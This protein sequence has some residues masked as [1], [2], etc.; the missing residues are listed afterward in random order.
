[1]DH[2]AA[3]SAAAR[4]A[5][6][7]RAVARHLALPGPKALRRS[8]ARAGGG[9]RLRNRISVSCSSSSRR[10]QRRPRIEKIARA[11]LRMQLPAATR[12]Q[13]VP[14]GG[15][16][17]D[18]AAH[19][20]RGTAAPAPALTTLPRFRAPLVFGGLA[21]LFAVLALRVAVSAMDRQRVSSRSREARATAARSRSPRTAA[22]SSTAR[23]SR[24]RSRR[25]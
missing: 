17:D 16:A 12:V 1:M 5:R 10:G 8:R 22:A 15:G 23:A 21:L 7:L 9:A 14:P 2:G 11:Q 24:S 25:R 19:A 6:R 20:L 18:A 13:V 4:G 3:Q